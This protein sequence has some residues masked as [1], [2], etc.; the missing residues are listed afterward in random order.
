MSD[1]TLPPAPEPAPLRSHR[2]TI[3][4]DVLARSQPEADHLV[5]EVLIEELAGPPEQLRT[6]GDRVF[7]E[8]FGDDVA[9]VLSWVPRSESAAAPLSEAVPSPE[10]APFEDSGIPE[11]VARMFP[12]FPSEDDHRR[13]DGSLNED[14]FEFEVQEWREVCLE[15]AVQAAQLPDLLAR[16]DQLEQAQT[17]QARI[18]ESERVRDGLIDLL[19]RD[20]LP[21]E[22]RKEDYLVTIAPSFEGEVEDMRFAWDHSQ[23]RSDFTAAALRR[24]HTLR[25]LL[26]EGGPRTTYLPAHFHRDWVPAGLIALHT[27]RSIVESEQP[28]LGISIEREQAAQLEA[29]LAAADPEVRVLDPDDPSGVELYAGPASEAHAWLPSGVYEATGPDGTGEF[30]LV[31]GPI[32]GSEGVTASAAFPPLEHD[33][34]ALSE[35]ARILEHDTEIADPATVLA[36]IN[37]TVTG[38]GRIGA[39]PSDLAR[40]PEP[41]TRIERGVLLSELLAEREQHLN[42]PA[43]GPEPHAP[44]TGPERNL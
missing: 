28:I 12:P 4:F 40:T 15:L 26:A 5:N 38:T 16:L 10:W 18:D 30:R 24:D 27:L 17:S 29:L 13:A 8:D 37:E 9:H 39:L 36:H 6:D 7:G 22:P 2:V 41:L 44:E 1:P 33:S 19:D 34:A 32:P 31:V 11:I 21:V 14:A 35:I 20:P 3:E 23:W 25:E 42:P 43:D